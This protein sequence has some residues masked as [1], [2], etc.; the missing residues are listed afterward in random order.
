MPESSLRAEIYSQ[1]DCWSVA[2]DLASRYSDLLPAPGERVGV[3]GCG[4][5]LFIARAYSF[6]REQ[7]GQGVTDAWPASEARLHRDYD[8][9]VALTRSGTTTEI[10]TAL[11]DYRAAGGT[12]PVTAITATPGT[13]VQSKG[14]T[15][16]LAEF[17]ETSVVQ[18]RFATSA[19]AL[20]RAHLGEDLG[21]VIAQAKEILGASP[22]E[23]E[24]SLA[25]VRSADQL[26]FVGMGL[27]AALAEEAALKLREATQSWAE[28]YPAT[29][30]RHGPVS[31]AQPGRAVWSL[32]PL[33]PGFTRDVA[34]TGAHLEHGDADP[35][36]E[37]VRVHLLCLLRAADLGLDPASP[38]N[39][40]R[41]VILA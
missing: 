39:L 26:T 35:M 25:A 9:I 1:P 21:P 28:S 18:T 10:L 30:Y 38:R 4:T 24:Q 8:R 22:A 33:V 40:T 19:L 37:L 34:A 29:E 14:D 15:I 16:T 32:G 36:A 41:A 3:I 2:A 12:A 17:D 6:L 7:A 31:I 11:D 20:L 23:L 27:G 5:S 13:P